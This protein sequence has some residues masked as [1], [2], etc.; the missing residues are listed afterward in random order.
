MKRIITGL[1][2]SVVLAGCGGSGQE[3]A[4]NAPVFFTAML[5]NVQALFDGHDS[6]NEYAEFREAAGWTAEKYQARLTAISQ[7][8]QQMAESAKAAPGLI[9]FVEVENAGVLEDLAGGTLSKQG[10]YWTAFTGLPGYS[11]GIGFLSRFPITDT[12]AHSITVE[13][14]TAPRP[15]LEVRVEPREKPLVFLLCHWKSKL[16]NDT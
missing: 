3:S 7:A 13:N 4:Q 8:V 6:G 1:I 9:G 12:R 16:G 15:V 10:Y 11:L 14:V 2:L 5:W